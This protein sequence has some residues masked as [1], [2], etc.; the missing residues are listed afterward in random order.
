MRPRVSCEVLQI[1]SRNASQKTSPNMQRWFSRAFSAS[2]LVAL[3]VLVGGLPAAAATP[4]RNNKAVV[5]PRAHR[6]DV[7]RRR[8]SPA[9]TLPYGPEYGFLKH[10]PPNAIR[11]PGYIFVPGVGILGES[12][13]LP[14]SACSNR[15]RDIQ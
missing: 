15:Y 6:S 11:M 12:C 9:R 1:T 5:S 14:T 13:D 10:V 2:L 3:A 7:V 8:Q 4:D